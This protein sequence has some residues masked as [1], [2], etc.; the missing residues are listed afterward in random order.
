MCREFQSEWDVLSKS[1]IRGDKPGDS[2][3][4]FG[5]LDFNEGSETFK[6]VGFYSTVFLLMPLTRFEQLLLQTA[7]VLLFFPPTIGPY[8]KVDGQPIRYDFSSG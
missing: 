4:I 2:R 5:T 6:K 1:W 3:L 7:P 8:A